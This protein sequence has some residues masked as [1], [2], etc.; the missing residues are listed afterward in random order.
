MVDYFPLIESHFLFLYM[1]AFPPLSTIIWRVIP[2]CGDCPVPFEYVAEPGFHRW[3]A[4]RNPQVVTTQVFFRYLNESW[5]TQ[6][7]TAPSYSRDICRVGHWLK[8]AII[9]FIGASPNFFIYLYAFVFSA[10]PACGSSQARDQTGS[11]CL[12]HHWCNAGSLT[13]L[14]M[15]LPYK[16][17]LVTIS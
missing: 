11:C 14:H 16:P 13:C 7:S 15:G 10:L 1:G 5:V 4:N 6:L 17:F 2:C 12:H 3:N 8:I 9:I